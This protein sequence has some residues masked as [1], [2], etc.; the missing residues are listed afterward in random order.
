VQDGVAL[1][2]ADPL[3]EAVAYH[4]GRDRLEDGG[5]KLTHCGFYAVLGCWVLQPGQEL[6]QLA[7][8]VVSVHR[9]HDVEQRLTWNQPGH[10]QH[11]IGAA[12]NYFR[13]VR[14]GRLF[15]QCSQ[16]GDLVR[17]PEC[18][19]L[20]PGELHHEPSVDDP[21]ADHHVGSSSFTIS[22]STIG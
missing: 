1:V 10:Q 8:G 18:R 11:G 21:V 4:V 14:D 2:W 15:S 9:V 19:G 12:G 13:Q 16:D 3:R 22:R 7:T 20:G 5:A 17:E 6:S